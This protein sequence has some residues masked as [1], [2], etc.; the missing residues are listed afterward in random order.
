[1]SRPM[2]LACTTMFPV[3][4]PEN[5]GDIAAGNGLGGADYHGGIL[6]RPLEACAVLRQPQ[7]MAM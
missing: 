5:L 3:T 6:R 2:F 1:M 7:A 4:T